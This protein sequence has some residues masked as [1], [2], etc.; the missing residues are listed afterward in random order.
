MEKTYLESNANFDYQSEII[1]NQLSKMD[2]QTLSKKETAI[3]IYNYVRDNW[4]YNPNIFSFAESD[5]KASVIISHK[6]G[7]CIDKAILLISF[8]RASNIPARLGLAKV[9]NH[10]AV[11]NIVAKFGSEELVPHG[12]VDIF[13]NDKWVKATPAFNEKLCHK[14]GVHVLEFDGENNS[15]FQEYDTTGNVQFMEYIEDYGTFDDV[16]LQFMF[17][18]MQ[19]NYPA[20]REKLIW[21]DVLDLSTL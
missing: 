5:W 15:L 10:I 19:E 2:L 14:L 18:L 13:L 12:Y 7:H 3:K 17:E 8:L 16:P 6:T 9:K 20:I 4:S 1:Q 11:E 21:G